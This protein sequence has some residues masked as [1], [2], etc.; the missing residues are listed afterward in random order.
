VVLPG[1]VAVDNEH[2]FVELQGA[3]SDDFSSAPPSLPAPWSS[4]TPCA[5][6]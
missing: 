5:S 2:C 4:E 1:L 3:S 6:A